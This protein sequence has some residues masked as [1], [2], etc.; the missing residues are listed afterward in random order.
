MLQKA[1]KKLKGGDE[2]PDGLEIASIGSLYAG[3]WDKKYWSS[4]RVWIFLLFSFVFLFLFLQFSLAFR[5]VSLELELIMIFRLF[6]RA[7]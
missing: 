3:P 4:S 2:K 7:I 1:M 6:I 5:V